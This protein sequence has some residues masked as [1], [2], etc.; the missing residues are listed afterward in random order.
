[1]EYFY[2]GGG[3]NRPDFT[4]RF[5]VKKITDEMYDWCDS[6]PLIGPFERWHIIH[7]Y[8]ERT[9]SRN[10]RGDSPETP[11]IQFES[12]KAAYMFR[13]AFSEY[14]I[15]NKTYGFAKQHL[16]EGFK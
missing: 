15:E 8:Y 12:R 9:D 11:L 14:I 10:D 4:Y 2:S 5:L 6:Y 16:E 3:N 13:I 1:M 7:N